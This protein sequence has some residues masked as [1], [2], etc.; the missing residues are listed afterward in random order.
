MG[1]TKSTIV[2]FLL[3]GSIFAS[4]AFQDVNDCVTTIVPIFGADTSFIDQGL[5]FGHMLCIDA[6]P[7]EETTVPPPVYVIPESPPKFA[8]YGPILARGNRARITADYNSFPV[9]SFDLLGMCF[10][11]LGSL[12]LCYQIYLCPSVRGTAWQKC[13]DI[14]NTSFKEVKSVELKSVALGLVEVIAGGVYDN[15]RVNLHQVH[16]QLSATG[17]QREIPIGTRVGHAGRRTGGNGGLFLCYSRRHLGSSQS[18]V[19]I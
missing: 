9:S 8:V 3:L 14:T 15:F 5:K 10:G 2:P 19:M 6:T 12:P 4:S 18:L 16:Q 17:K 13:V 11:L 1:Q 7:P